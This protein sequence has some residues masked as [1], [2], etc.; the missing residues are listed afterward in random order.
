MHKEIEP[1]SPKKSTADR[2]AEMYNRKLAFRM[3]EAESYGFGDVA[4]NRLL[5]LG[6]LKRENIIVE[7]ARRIMTEFTTFPPEISRR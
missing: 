5:G 2:A 1:I 4:V 3:R 6:S 7:E